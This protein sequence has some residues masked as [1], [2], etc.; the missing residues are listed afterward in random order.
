MASIALACLERL[1]ACLKSRVGILLTP[2]LA[3]AFPTFQIRVFL[4]HAGVKIVLS[5]R[6]IL[7]VADN[8]LS[9]QAVVLCQRNKGQMQMGRFTLIDSACGREFG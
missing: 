2:C 1:A 8:L 6:Q 5:L 9:T 7:P 4:C 3:G